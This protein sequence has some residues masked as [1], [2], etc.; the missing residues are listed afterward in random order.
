MRNIESEQRAALAA[1]EI[2]HRFLMEEGD[3]PK[4]G[5]VLGT[6]W[7]GALNW[8]TIPDQARFDEIPGFEDLQPLEGHARQVYYGQIEGA[9]VIALS[10]RVHLNEAPCSASIA[11]MVRLQIEM[12]ISLGVETLILHGRGRKSSI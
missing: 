12:L 9:N 1:E 11:K 6:G 7:G 8:Q 3:I 4:I 5:I 10:G 2:R